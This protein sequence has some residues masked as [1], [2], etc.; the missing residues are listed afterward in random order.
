MLPESKTEEAINYLAKRYRH[1]ELGMQ[2]HQILVMKLSRDSLSIRKRL[3]ET[4]ADRE[5]HAQC[6]PSPS[7]EA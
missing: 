7:L 4:H 3:V 1:F 6:G 2:L 5:P